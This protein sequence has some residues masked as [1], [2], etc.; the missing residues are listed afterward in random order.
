MKI[1]EFKG[2]RV[3]VMGL[4]LHGGG[5]GVTRWLIR[6]GAKV[7]V[8]D[9]KTRKQLQ[10]SIALLRGLKV[11]FVLGKHP[12]ADFKNTD[13]IIQNPGVP[14]ESKFLK[15]AEQNGVPIATDVSI[16]F[17]YCPAPI[18]GITGT[19]GKTT[20]T[21]LAGEIFKKLD[22]KTVVAGNIRK[23]PLDDLDKIAADTP[24]VLELSSWQLE[25][26]ARI[27]RS[28]RISL[29]TN[30][31]PDHLNRYKD[32]E[33]YKS[34]KKLVYTFQTPD[35]S[36]ILNRDNRHTLAM[37][38]EVLSRR[39]WFSKKYFA[40]ENGSF[41]T[42]DGWIKF[43]N[44]GKETRVLPVREIKLLGEHNL[45]NILGAVA[46]AGVAGAPAKIIRSA[47][48]NFKG[49][50]SRLELVREVGGVKY[51]NDTTATAPDAAIT[52][53]K[54]LG[55]KK[56][57]IILLS[58]GADKKLDFKEL[59]RYIKKY[60]KSVILFKG[61]ASEKILK[62]LKNIKYQKSDLPSRTSV[63]SVEPPAGIPYPILTMSD[64]VSWAKEIA[65]RGDIVLLSPGA[66]SFGLFINEFDRGDQFVREVRNL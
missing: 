13:L 8:T 10:K 4:G 17:E 24:V 25:G 61:D 3:T 1:S 52:S 40:G 54:A 38:R 35:D 59:A 16:F 36:V 57:N 41:I 21:V 44:N 15:I 62:E 20:T 37:G 58:G 18:F 12:E 60:T 22:K 33:D 39:F 42:P 30:I 27:K 9:L 19:K 6:H 32:L 43:R 2:R 63:S 34:A 28:P 49:V 66:A 64:A 23:S 55:G 48:K 53:L 26:L 65:T 47:I 50:P 56:K 11:K 7:L 5:V 45:E 46:M 31:F 29:I 14:R 51:I